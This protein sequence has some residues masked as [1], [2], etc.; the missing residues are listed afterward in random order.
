MEKKSLILIVDDNEEN[1]T[2]ISRILKSNDYDV[3]YVFSGEEA[4]NSLKTNIPDLI[5][6]DIM[7]PK[8]DGIETCKVIQSD[9]KYKDIPI[10]FLSAKNEIETVVN[11]FEAGGKDYVTKPFREE[12]I[13]SRVKTH[14]KV[15]YLERERESYLQ[16]LSEFYEKTQTELDLAK[17]T[18][19]A[20]IAKEFPK[21]PKCNIYN[22]FKPYNKIGGD[23][24][25]YEWKEDGTIDILFGDVSGHGLSSALISGIIVLAFKIATSKNPN[26]EKALKKIHE[27]VFPIV[28]SHHLSAIYL[29]YNKDSNELHYSYAG[30]HPMVLI[31]EGSCHKLDGKGS[32]VMAHTEVILNSYTHFLEKGDK[33]LLYSD[34]LIEVENKETGNILG[35]KLFIEY[36]QNNC[37]Q[38]GQELLENLA[39]FT[40]DF[41]GG[42]LR[43]DMSMLLLE[44]F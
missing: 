7:M 23:L 1:A 14:L 13:L 44:F 5:L 22:Y 30:H 10:L 24:I 31:R 37:D 42:D 43:D 28:K 18:Q 26:P 38:S 19:N 3:M 8:M 12:E 36:Y 40:T 15:Y 34:G 25:A 11:A 17:E 4:I 35:N 27:L 9:P 2:I 29:Q 41:C 6:M 39:N 32:F 16:K 33:I 20:I 21:L